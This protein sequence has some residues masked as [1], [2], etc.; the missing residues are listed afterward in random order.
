MATVPKSGA[1][2]LTGLLHAPSLPVALIL[3]ALVIGVAALLPLVQSSGATSIAGNIHLLEQQKTD[4]Q[5]RLRELEVEVA[6]L[7]SLNRIEQ[8]AK[9]RFKM[10]PPNEVHYIRVDAPAPQEDRL[11][12]RFLP[13]QPQHADNGSSLWEDLF[14]WVPLP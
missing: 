8:E 3:A 12:S 5:A 14:G 7:G 4:A 6:Q 1:G 10:G 2:A 11:P 9:A 13:P